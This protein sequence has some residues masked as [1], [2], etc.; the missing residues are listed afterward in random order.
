M[1]DRISELAAKAADAVGVT[2]YSD[3]RPFVMEAV[4]FA[5][6]P[7]NSGLAA[8]E[9]F[10]RVMEAESNQM[11]EIAISLRHRYEAV[12]ARLAEALAEVAEFKARY[13]AWRPIT[14]TPNETYILSGVLFDFYCED[15]DADGENSAFS[16]VT[17]W[18]ER[19]EQA[20][21]WCRI[22]TPRWPTAEDLNSGRSMAGM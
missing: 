14:E 18:N 20:S 7:E 11:R 8:A 22:V 10:G 3:I 17:T 6:S 21:M 13:E 16:K 1:G 19:P 4:R 15:P 9:E 5:L 12:D 2:R